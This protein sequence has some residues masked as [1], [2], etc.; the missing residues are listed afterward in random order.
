MAL[1]YL[2]KDIKEPSST[3]STPTGAQ[4]PQ[5]NCQLPQECVWAPSPLWCL[6]DEMHE[7]AQQ[8]QTQHPPPPTEA[9]APNQLPQRVTILAEAFKEVSVSAGALQVP[10]PTVVP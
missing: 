10:Y 8:T 9:H 5:T 3:Q 7:R 4:T 1:I 2:T 6:T